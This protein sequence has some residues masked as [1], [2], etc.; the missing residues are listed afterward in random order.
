MT[1]TD[2]EY[3]HYLNNLIK[4][5]RNPCFEILD[6]LISSEFNVHNIYVDLFQKSLYQVG[7]MWEQN[8]IS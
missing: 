8:K 3:D 2:S 1:K 6:S 7:K 5:K 4:G